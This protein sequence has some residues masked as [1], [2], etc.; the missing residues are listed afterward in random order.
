MLCTRTDSLHL[1]TATPG[2]TAQYTNTANAKYPTSRAR[3]TSHTPPIRK[4]NV[5]QS[6]RT[7][8]RDATGQAGA[9]P[10]GAP[11]ETK[12]PS[13]WTCKNIIMKNS[14]SHEFSSEMK[15][16][17]EK[18]WFAWMSIKQMEQQK[19]T[20]STFQLFSCVL[21]KH[22]WTQQKKQVLK[23]KAELSTK[24]HCQRIQNRFWSLQNI[25][26]W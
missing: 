18:Q 9:V 14:D 6:H 20:S 17:V 25:K 21:I 7:S 24:K 4:H 15:N 23:L 3:A 10:P 1:S 22:L 13:Q 8:W 11:S 2:S 12:N 19:G 26:H 5:P 16:N